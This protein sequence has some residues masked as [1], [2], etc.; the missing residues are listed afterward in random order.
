M[1]VVARDYSMI[2]PALD[3]LN[4]AYG[5]KSSEISQLTIDTDAGGVTSL[6]VKLWV[7]TEHLEDQARDRM[8]LVPMIKPDMRDEV[9]REEPYAIGTCTTCNS[10]IWA[11]ASDELFGYGDWRG[12]ATPPAHPVT[13]SIVVPWDRA[14][15]PSDHPCAGG[16]CH[17]P[18]AHAEGAHD[19]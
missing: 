13:P 14:Q 18:Q 4:R 11:Y 19:L 9:P 17:D 8:R 15:Q 16:R 12:C 1:S 6:T 2:Q 3:Y 5:L 10:R 7:R